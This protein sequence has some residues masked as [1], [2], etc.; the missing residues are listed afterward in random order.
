MYNGCLQER[1][2]AY[3]LNGIS[4]GYKQQ[5]AQLPD[6]KQLNSDYAGIYSTV[7]QNVLKRADLAFQNFFRRVKNNE[8]PG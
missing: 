7:V 8:T 6:I 5:S 3:R 2:D 4:I 1:S